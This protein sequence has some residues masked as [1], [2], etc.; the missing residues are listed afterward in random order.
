M[1]PNDK[2]NKSYLKL[3]YN[4][5]YKKKNCQF[6]GRLAL[7]KKLSGCGPETMVFVRLVLYHF[8]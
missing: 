3:N 8:L 5:S 2:E 1:K 4:C 7:K 6:T